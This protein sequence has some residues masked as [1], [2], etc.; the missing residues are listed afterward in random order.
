MN[1]KTITRVVVTVAVLNALL[2]IASALAGRASRAE[3]TGPGRAAVVSPLARRPAAESAPEQQAGIPI[4]MIDGALMKR[5]ATTAFLPS[6][7]PALD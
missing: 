6:G 4:K 2:V 5:G 7:E 1:Q 3:S